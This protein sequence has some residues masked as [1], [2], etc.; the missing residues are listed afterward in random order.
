MSPSQHPHLTVNL[1]FISDVEAC[2]RAT[3]VGGE[4]QEE[5]VG[6]GN[7]EMRRLGAVVFANQGRRGRGAISYFKSVIVDLSLEPGMIQN[8]TM[9][10]MHITHLMPFCGCCW[11]LSSQIRQGVGAT[12]LLSVGWQHLTGCH[13]SLFPATTVS[14]LHSK[15]SSPLRCLTGFPLTLLSDSLLQN[16]NLC[17]GAGRAS[18]A[19]SRT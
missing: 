7:Q 12:T 8:K 19:Q 16:K 14:L 9:L 4:Q 6:G 18:T 1:T 17:T 5:D 15:V 10:N 3:V 2:C 11:F 13:L